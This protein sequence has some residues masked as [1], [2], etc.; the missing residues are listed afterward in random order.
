MSLVIPNERFGINHIKQTFDGCIVL[1]VCVLSRLRLNSLAAPWFV[2]ICMTI[3]MD[4][5]YFADRIG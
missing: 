3:Y 2:L 4:A 1:H 5:I